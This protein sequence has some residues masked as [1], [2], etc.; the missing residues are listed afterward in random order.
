MD[1]LNSQ[2]DPKIT[3]EKIY[4]FWTKK[5]FFDPDK[6]KPRPKKNFSIV[7]PPPNITGSLHMGH[8]LNSVIQDI[9]VRYYRMNGYHTVW[10]PGTDHGG[11]SAE[12]V[13]GKKL[14]KEGINKFELGRE[15]FL[16]KVWEWREEYGNKILAQ[17]KKI[18]A[19][20]DWSRTAFTMDPGYIKAIDKAFI[21]FHEKGWVYRAERVVNWCPRCK[22]S[23][24][25]LEL[26]HSEEKSSLW[27]IKYPLLGDEKKFVVVATTRPETMLGDSAVAVNPKDIRYKD[28]VG[29]NL[30]LPIANRVIPIVADSLVDLEFGTGA[31]K[32]TPAHDLTDA[33]IGRRHNL[34]VIKV[35]NEN[36]RM[37]DDVA[38]AY[39]GLKAAEARQMIVEE[40]TAAGLIEKIEPYVHQVPKCYRC[41]STIELI[42]SKQWFVKMED[43]SKTAIKAVRSNK[44]RFH[45]KRWEKVFF[46]WQRNTRDWCVSRQLWWGERLPVWFCQ[47]EPDNY[48]VSAREPKKCPF[49]KKCA[50]E[51]STDVFDTWFS[52]ALW[53]FASFGWPKAAKDLDNF[54]PTS[55]LSTARDI[56]NLWV[57]RMIFCSLELTGKIPFSDVIIHA[58]VLTK[59]G[60]RMS[61]SLGT[62]ID[63][64]LLIDKY[65]ADGMRFGLAWQITESQ[66]LHFNEDNMLAGKKFC[67]KL[68]NASRF[69]LMQLQGAKA[70]EYSA[71][72][73]PAAAAKD[74]RL[75][76]KKLKKIEKSVSKKIESYAFGAAA[77]ELY[78]FFWHDFCDIYIEKAKVAIRDAKSPKEADNLRASLI[79]V[80]ANSLKLLHPFIPFITEEIYS[81]IPVKNKKPL[82]VENWPKI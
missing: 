58:T 74:T 62:G 12:S 36:A 55:V 57:A 22:T 10:L 79:Y 39:R 14:H 46:D 13:V 23:L 63:P 75:I 76:L 54:F 72:T 80:L 25:D 33:E 21:H 26:E 34:P 8:A 53:P 32:V 5:G 16:E 45:P 27:H 64:L 17:L 56:I 37:A 28:L 81:I 67:N 69:A 73:E 78:E 71:D 77:K 38:V 6:I 49:C 59:D 40:L 68:W 20:C 48:V 52:S 1:N 82:I 70:R 15:K 31:V 30:V 19:S 43:L 61:K 11:I 50:M 44:V 9:L 51:R 24:S 18:G 35:I 29:K 7:L 3:E 2:Y 47:K 66:D 65:G 60:R 42:P 4:A 41:N